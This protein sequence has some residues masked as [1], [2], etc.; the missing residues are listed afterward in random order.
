MTTTT[1]SRGH[2]VLDCGLHVGFEQLEPGVYVSRSGGCKDVPAG[3]RWARRG[4]W[5][6]WWRRLAAGLGRAMRAEVLK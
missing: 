4:L 3:P 6:R 5:R 2:K 1:C